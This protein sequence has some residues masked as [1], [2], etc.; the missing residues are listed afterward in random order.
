MLCSPEEDVAH[1]VCAVHVAVKRLDETQHT[2]LHKKLLFLGRPAEV[3]DDVG[4]AVLHLVVRDV[5]QCLQSPEDV[6][7]DEHLAIAVVN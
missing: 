7:V 4:S 5:N 6:A 2:V 1:G 3:G